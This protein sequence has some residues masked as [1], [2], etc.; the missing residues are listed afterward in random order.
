VEALFEYPQPFAEEIFDRLER[1]LS[2]RV[3]D[4]EPGAAARTGRIFIVPDEDYQ[5][6]PG[7]SSVPPLP[8]RYIASTDPQLVAAQKAVYCDEPRLSSDR[9]EGRCVLSF[10]TPGGWVAITKAV[11]T[12]VLGA[13]RDVK[14]AGLPPAA[15][16]VLPLMCP[17]LAM[18]PEDLPP[19]S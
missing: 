1:A 2:R 3:S 10:R 7:A 6:A 18:S 17:A 14:I 19:R 15:A 4:G 8:A 16:G 12:E 9:R 11:L 13:G 5:A